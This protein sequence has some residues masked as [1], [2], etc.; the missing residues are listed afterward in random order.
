MLSP[1]EYIYNTIS[2]NT[3]K[4]RQKDFSDQGRRK[5]AVRLSPRNDR[6]APP[7]IL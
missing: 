7:M 4:E 2:G 5:S 1:S 3:E 6:G